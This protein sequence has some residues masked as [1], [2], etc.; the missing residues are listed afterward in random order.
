MKGEVSGTRG[1]H[2]RGCDSKMGDRQ[3]FKQINGVQFI[4]FQIWECKFG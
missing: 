2:N 1:L 3:S 4:D